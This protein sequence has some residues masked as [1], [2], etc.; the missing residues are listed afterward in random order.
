M[1]FDLSASAV[2][3]SRTPAILDLRLRDL[4]AAWQLNNEGG[5]SWSPYDIV[6]HFIHG[7]LTDWMPRMEIILA[8]EDLHFE[9]Y[10]RFA[11]EKNSIGKSMSDLLEEFA[12]LRKE[13]VK[14]LQARKLDEA[15]LNLKGIHPDFGE[16]TL[17]NLLSTWV[18]HDMAH[19]AQIARVM[20]KQY[21]DAVGPW[22]NYMPILTR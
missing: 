2:I 12:M 22:V 14:K 18:A 20:A 21:N 5:D 7:E 16:L 4:P 6:G 1:D 19:M 15:T 17:S 13:N 3:L 10:D 8:Q 11:Q 9:P